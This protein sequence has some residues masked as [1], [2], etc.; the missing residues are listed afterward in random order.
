MATKPTPSK[1]KSEKAPSEVLEEPQSKAPSVEEGSEHREPANPPTGSRT[2]VIDGEGDL[3][4]SV[5][6]QGRSLPRGV[7]IEV[8]PDIMEALG[9][10]SSTT[11]KEVKK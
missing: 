9:E 11:F 5:K 10:S 7:P 1:A 6:G 8:G 4:L 3:L 2:I